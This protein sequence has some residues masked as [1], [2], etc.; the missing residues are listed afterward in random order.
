VAEK[1]DGTHCPVCG[2]AARMIGAPGDTH[3]IECPTCEVLLGIDGTSV[4]RLHRVEE[5]E[6]GGWSIFEADVPIDLGAEGHL[7]SGVLA[8][9]DLD[10][11][12]HCLAYEGPLWRAEAEEVRRRWLEDVAYGQENQQSQI[13]S[14][15]GGWLSGVAPTA[16][17]HRKDKF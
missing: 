17:D 6:D 5:A 4:C 8:I 10:G 12:T 3:V 14:A 1:T 2:A 7:S 9:L 16:L 15:V 13:T 11:V